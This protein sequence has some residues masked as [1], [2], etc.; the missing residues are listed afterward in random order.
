MGMSVGARPVPVSR[1]RFGWD[2][3]QTSERATL[4]EPK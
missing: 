4:A 3:R 2:V 1:L